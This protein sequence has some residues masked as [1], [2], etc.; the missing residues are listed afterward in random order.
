MMSCKNTLS[1]KAST[2]V[3]H[4]EGIII[5]AGISPAFDPPHPRMAVGCTNWRGSLAL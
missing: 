5:A 1:R 2:Q 4:A 3:D